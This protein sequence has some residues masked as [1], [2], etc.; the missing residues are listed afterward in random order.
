MRSAELKQVFVSVLFQFYFSCAYSFMSLLWVSRRRQ[1]LRC[2]H[3]LADRTATQCDRL[4]AWYCRLS[5]TKCIVT[6]RYILQLKFSE[7]VNRNCPLRTR[8]YNFQPSYTDPILPNSPPTKFRNFTLLDDDDDDD[9]LYLTF[10][11][12]WPFYLCCNER[13]RVLLSRCS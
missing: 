11:V 3:F 7:R 9:L 8:F 4:L 5:M 1:I 2:K 12:T 6:K 10:L 13:G